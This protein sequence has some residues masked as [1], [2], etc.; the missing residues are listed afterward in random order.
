MLLKLLCLAYWFPCAMVGVGSLVYLVG[1]VSNYRVPATI[2]LGFSAYLPARD[3]LR[4]DVPLLLLFGVQ[5][6]LMARRFVKRLVPMHWL[7]STYLLATGLVLFYIFRKWEPMPDLVWRFDGFGRWLAAALVMAGVVLV[8]WSVAALGASDF[9]GLRA[10][11]C[12]VFRR[13]YRPPPRARGPYLYFRHPMMLGMMLVVWSTA[14]MS[15]GHLLFASFLLA[16]ALVGTRL[17]AADDRRLS[18]AA[19]AG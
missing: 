12:H 4:A 6:S 17:E 3:A 11:L 15:Q 2:D 16:Y 14:E 13:E 19:P 18:G 10:V 5:H 1:F 7:R 9:L 8:V